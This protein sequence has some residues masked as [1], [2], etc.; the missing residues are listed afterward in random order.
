MESGNS[1]Q[2]SDGEERHAERH[3]KAR[4][5]DRREH[6]RQTAFQLL[7]PT[8]AARLLHRVLGRQ[9]SDGLRQDVVDQVARRLGFV[10]T[11]SASAF[12]PWLPQ[13][14]CGRWRSSADELRSPSASRLAACRPGCSARRASTSAHCIPE[15]I[16]PA[17]SLPAYSYVVTASP[18]PFVPDLCD[19]S[20][21]PRA[22]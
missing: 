17:I 16:S 18:V 2:H 1:Q 3:G 13:P 8:F 21:F 7:E 11:P 9:G 12:Q 6:R 15:W 20:R 4:G 14:W 19:S 22:H 10:Q 5:G